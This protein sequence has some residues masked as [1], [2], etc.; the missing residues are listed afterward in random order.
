MLRI[1]L[2]AGGKVINGRAWLYAEL[3]TELMYGKKSNRHDCGMPM[4]IVVDP[5]KLALDSIIGDEEGTA[6]IKEITKQLNNHYDILRSKGSEP[7]PMAVRDAFLGRVRVEYVRPAKTFRDALASTI[8]SKD[9]SDS[10]KEGLRY[11]ASVIASFLEQEYTPA[12]GIASVDST[13]IHRFDAWLMRWTNTKR[14][15]KAVPLQKG[16]RTE[17]RN[18]LRS[19]IEHCVRVGMIKDDPY[20]NYTCA[21]SRYNKKKGKSG[22]RLKRMVNVTDLEV[23]E[24]TIPRI[25]DNADLEMNLRRTRFLFLF[26][27]WAGWSFIDMQNLNVE[28]C[29]IT[30]LGG[31]ATISYN[32]VK[33]G[34]LGIVP[35]FPETRA[36]LQELHNKVKSEFSGDHEADRKSYRLK[37]KAMFRWYGLSDDRI[38]AHAGRHAFGNRMLDL[39]YSMES[40]SRM[41]GHNSIETTQKA[42]AR[43]DGTKIFADADRL[44]RQ[45]TPDDLRHIQ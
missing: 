24:A 1:K 20:R 43:V 44:K 35:M 31:N 30:D 3:E 9:L 6:K 38:G 36:I 16:T 42:Y 27:T 21:E 23:I 34:E 2:R 12:F 14:G 4:G 10:R 29:M 19:V 28:D 41:M 25:T 15:R 8:A 39:G 11:F 18:R 22:M 13:F 17:Y 37:V 45:A 7:H 26:Q 33:T 5:T 40:V 32:R